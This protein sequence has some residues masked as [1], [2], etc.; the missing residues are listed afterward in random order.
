MINE[1]K[2][3]NFMLL[4]ITHENIKVAKEAKSLEKKF[5][6]TENK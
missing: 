6:R 4:Q 2:K 3:E 1:I 5:F